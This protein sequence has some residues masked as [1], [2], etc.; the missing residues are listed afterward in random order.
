MP[1]AVPIYQK[2]ID[3]IHAKVASGELR[4]GDK[5]PTINEFK[6]E[7]KCSNE[8]V[9]AALRILSSSGATVGHQGR[10]HYIAPGPE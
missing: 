6:A 8:P 1:S 10:G 5:L 9:K 2:I 4:P 7:Y 3:D